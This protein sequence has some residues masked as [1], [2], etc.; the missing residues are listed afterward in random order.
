[1][2]RLRALSLAL[3]APALGA[4]AQPAWSQ[5][6]RDLDRACAAAAMLVLPDTRITQAQAI[7]PQP[8]YLVPETAHAAPGP[9]GGPVRVTRPFCRVAGVVEPAIRFEVW[10]PLTG[11]NGRFEGLGLGAFSGAVPYAQMAAALAEG[12]AVG[13]TDTGHESGGRDATWAMTPQGTLNTTA[14]EDWIYR[15]IHA[16]TQKSQAVVQAVYGARARHSYFVG[17]S[18]GGHQALTEAQ[19]YPDDYDGIVAGAPANYWTHLMA[20]QMWYGLA[21]RV[22]PASSLELP[23]DKL[24]LIHQ[25]ALKACDARDGVRD[26]VIENPL[27]CRFDPRVLA[28]RGPAGPDCLTAPQVQALLKIYGGARERDGRQIFP[29]F[30]PGSEL[31]WK[32][33]M[34]P[35]VLFAQ[36]FYRYLVFQ[37]PAWDYTHMDFARDVAYADQR[38]GAITNSV[39]ADLAP[40][41][42]HGGKLLQYHGW[43]DPGISPYNSVNYYESVV[44]KLDPGKARSAALQDVQGFYRLFM[45]PGMGHCRGGGTDSFD[46]L[47]ALTSW[48]EQGRAP[49]R[50]EA[51]RMADGKAVET[52]PLCPYPRVA[53]YQGSGSTDVAANFKCELPTAAA[54]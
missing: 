18:S 51:A 3:L 5:A 36:N 6:P 50:I 39:D 48:V 19:R 11:W 37:N 38:V 17:C 42:A 2:P 25:A 32:T 23:T 9:F 29:G 1:M 15:G 10:L 40:F 26:G 13:G 20:G 43:A 46:A 24:A 4:L 27:S 54:H 34:D 28:C 35:Q 33:M 49:Q 44:A 31:G 30:A 22:D 21:T 12:Y 41:R 47:G 16:M 53:R 14:V 45:V 52:R 7:H 8:Q